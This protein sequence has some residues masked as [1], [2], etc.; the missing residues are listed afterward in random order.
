MRRLNGV[1][2]LQ[3]SSA[4]FNI[5][6]KYY[7]TL[8]ISHTL[9]SV[10]ENF[11]QFFSS[12]FFSIFWAVWVQNSKPD[13]KSPKEMATIFA[14]LIDRETDGGVAMLNAYPPYGAVALWWLH[15]PP[16]TN[17]N[18]YR[19]SQTSRVTD[20]VHSW[21]QTVGCMVGSNNSPELA[22]TQYQ[23]GTR[24][25]AA[26]I[27]SVQTSIEWLL[28]TTNRTMTTRIT[29]SVRSRL[30][31]QYAKIT[32]ISLTISTSTSDCLTSKAYICCTRFT[33]L[34]SVKLVW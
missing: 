5:W 27:T 11:W 6:R 2:W 24:L 1:N 8:H 28:V 31:T 3:F 32:S 4:N 14:R 12:A 16:N 26:Y 18:R 7:A 23:Q 30:P 19:Q 29:T 13:N 25:S 17:K 21:P 22:H 10:L 33:Y 9:L 15:E 34:T 20:L